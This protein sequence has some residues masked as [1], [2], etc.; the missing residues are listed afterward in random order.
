MLSD[1]A[2]IY[3]HPVPTFTPREAKEFLIDRIVAEA[4]REN[5]PLSETERRMLYFTET[6]WMPWD[7]VEV[8]EAFERDYD[9]PEYEAKIAAI[10]RSYL[11]QAN[12]T[13]L[14]RWHEAV[15][16]LSDEDHYL[17]VMVS[18]ANRKQIPFPNG[19]ARLVNNWGPT[20]LGL[21]IGMGGSILVIA[22]VVLYHSLTR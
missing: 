19:L 13:D 2:I 9:M 20:R 14:E 16:V 5:V 10:I 15:R 6:Y 21:V 8:N 17:L 3:H 1:T 11:E 12:P 18:E 4:Q 7:F 22:A